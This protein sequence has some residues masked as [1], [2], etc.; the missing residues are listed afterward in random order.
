MGERPFKQQPLPAATYDIPLGTTET[1]SA[2]FKLWSENLT[3]LGVLGFIPYL[4]MM[5]MMLGTGVFVAAAP[6]MMGKLDDYW[7]LMVAGGTAMGALFMVM[8]LASTAACIHLVDEKTQGTDVTVGA[9]LLA[10]FKH[11]GWMF[12]ACIL[13][14]VVW[15]VGLAAPIIPLAWGMSED[16]YTIAAAALPALV[17][18]AA[19]FFVAVRLLPMFP[20]I[21]V[22]DADVFTATSRAWRLTAPHTWQLV[23]ATF[24]FGVCYMG[25]SMAAGMVGIV[26]IIGAFIQMGVNALLVPLCWVFAFAVYAGCVSSEATR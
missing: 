26:P 19:M 5:P 16:S 7:P 6:E 25:V 3:R 23:G 20:V 15:M 13:V 17:V 4:V 2:T 1:L 21:V 9:A 10:S 14:G 12:V 11:I 22:E 8:S 18:T 24:L